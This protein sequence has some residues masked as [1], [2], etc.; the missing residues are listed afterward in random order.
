MARVIRAAVVAVPGLLL[1]LAR[2][3]SKHRKACKRAT[4]YGAFE[5]GTGHK[6]FRLMIVNLTARKEITG[7]YSHHIRAAK[8]V[9][10]GRQKP[11]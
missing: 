6:S 11:L 4:A 1:V 2:V 9:K 3:T 5:R 8:T 7:W 10:L